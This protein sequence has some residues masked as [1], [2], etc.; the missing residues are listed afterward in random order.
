MAVNSARQIT[1]TL[2]GDVEGVQDPEAAE[3]AASPGT[4]EVKT[5]AIGFNSITVP[6]VVGVTVTA[7]TI[8]PPAGNAQSL[9]LKGITGD[10]GIR[11]HNTDPTSLAID[12]SVTAIGLTAGASIVG[13]RF[14]WS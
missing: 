8:I 9:T 6:A 2:T 7:V 11:L 1:I 5:L 4:I 14:I 3:N 10:T 13:V 12:S